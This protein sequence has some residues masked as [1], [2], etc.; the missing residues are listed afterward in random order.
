MS[1]RIVFVIDDD[2]DLRSAI[3]ESLD[4]EGYLVE[5]FSRAEEGLEAVSRREPHVVIVDRWLPTMKGDELIAA[6]RAS[7]QVV[8]V[9]L[10]SGDARFTAPLP[11]DVRVLP[12]P[13][14]MNQLL[15]AVRSALA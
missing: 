2:E 14:D 13:F 15:E 6:L 5:G 11:D 3:C 7:R 9:V 4:D 1:P 10:M 12:K 8:P